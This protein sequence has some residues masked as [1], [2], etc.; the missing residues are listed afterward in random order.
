MF[1]RCSFH[2]PYSEALIERELKYCKKSDSAPPLGSRED[3]GRVSGEQSRP[4]KS[5]KTSQLPNSRL[6]PPAQLL[7]SKPPST[8]KLIRAGPKSGWRKMRLKIVT[9]LCLQLPTT[10]RHCSSAEIGKIKQ[11]EVSGWGWTGGRGGNVFPV[12]IFT[13]SNIFQP[14]F[15]FPTLVCKGSWLMMVPFVTE[16]SHPHC[17]H[18]N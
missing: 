5:E 6:L 2:R 18:L 4:G 16:H 1:Y 14:K 3:T 12:F 8:T 13:V 10:S 7:L 11:G 15:L 9:S 17:L